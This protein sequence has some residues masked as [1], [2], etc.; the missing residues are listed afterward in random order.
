[1]LRLAVTD[2]GEYLPECMRKSNGVLSKWDQQHLDRTQRVLQAW[3]T[4]DPDAATT[5]AAVLR[6]A[7]ADADSET[8]ARHG[9]LDVVMEKIVQREQENPA[10]NGREMIDDFRLWR[11]LGCRRRGGPLT[12]G[13]WRM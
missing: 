4:R 5:Q 6:Q 3:T 1:M 7:I 9:G 12:K 13:G 8:V 10:S 11:S 2:I